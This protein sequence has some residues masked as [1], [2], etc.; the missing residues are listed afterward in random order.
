MKVNV[1]HNPVPSRSQ[2]SFTHTHTHGYT[3]THDVCTKAEVR[4]RS[5]GTYTPAPVTHPFTDDDT[6]THS[7]LTHLNLP[8]THIVLLHTEAAPSVHTRFKVRTHR[9]SYT[10]THRST[11]PVI[12]VH[13]INTLAPYTPTHLVTHSRNKHS[14][15]HTGHLTHRHTHGP[16]MFPVLRAGG[17]LFCLSPAA[18]THTDTPGHHVGRFFLVQCRRRVIDSISAGRR[19]SEYSNYH[20]SYANDMQMKVHFN[21][22]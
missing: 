12:S 11:H 1:F 8:H 14:T 16:V 22:S 20:I 6:P 7:D 2:V 15:E 9:Y 21:I 3:H 17:Q 13:Q 18:H 19:F 4:G 5:K 10:L